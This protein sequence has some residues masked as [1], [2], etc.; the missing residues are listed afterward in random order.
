MNHAEFKEHIENIKQACQAYMGK[1]HYWIQTLSLQP[2]ALT[3]PHYYPICVKASQY[4]K[5]LFTEC[6][7]PKDT[8]ITIYPAH[9]RVDTKN[10]VQTVSH[11]EGLPKP[12]NA[13]HL[14]LSS[15][16]SIIGCGDLWEHP[17]FLGHMINDSCSLGRLKKHKEADWLYHYYTQAKAQTNVRFV[18][19]NDYAYILT[20]KDIKA[21][22]ELFVAYGEDYWFVRKGLPNWKQSVLRYIYRLP[23]HKRSFFFALLHSEDGV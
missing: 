10:K 7:I 14:R 15:S 13:Y 2:T 9:Y 20:T 21:G 19:A 1:E 3:L 6:D 22:E 17:W 16:L 12:D 5:G 8:V 23:E 18:I 4:G 11:P